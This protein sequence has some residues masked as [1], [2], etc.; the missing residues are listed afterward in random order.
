MNIALFDAKEYDIAGFTAAAGSDLSIRFFYDRLN[1][2]NADLARGFEAVCP[3]V[4]DRLFA[5]TL[6]RLREYG[7]GMVALR[8]AGFNNVDLEAADRLGI[9]VANVPAYSPGGV[10]EHTLALILAL[11]RKIHKAYLRTRE[12]NFSLRG[13][14]G[15][16]MS[17]KTAGVVGL[18]RIGRAVARLLA[19]FGC[20]VVAYDPEN[21]PPEEGVRLTSLDELWRESD[22]ITLHCPLTAGTRHL[23]GRESIAAMKPGVMIINTSRG[24]LIDTEALIEGIKS[25]KVSSVGLDVYEE[26]ADYFYEDFTDSILE[27]DVLLELLALPNV[28]VTSHQA[29]FTR[30][31]L[32]RIA[33]VTVE[34]IRQYAAGLPVVNRVRARPAP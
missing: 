9:V 19:A 3:F 28:L 24:G 12:Y 14:M 31:A 22:I 10:A 16:E 30:E 23:V 21:P 15:F 25:R 33:A 17:G 29:F 32:E 27:D 6:E 34:N 5:G 13:L 8:C 1:E 4:N 7:V 26:E 11:N 18:G 2:R 20:R